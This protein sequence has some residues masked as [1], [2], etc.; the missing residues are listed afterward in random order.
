MVDQL[1]YAISSRDWEDMDARPEDEFEGED[2]EEL[3][4]TAPGVL[5]KAVPSLHY[6]AIARGSMVEDDVA[7]GGCIFGGRSKWWR[8]LAGGPNDAVVKLKEVDSRAGERLDM[9]L[10][11]ELFSKT[12]ELGDEWL[13]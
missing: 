1:G 2:W 8:V 7:P 13:L 5:A 4:E 10:R 3:R 9:H 12:L 6:I 11:S